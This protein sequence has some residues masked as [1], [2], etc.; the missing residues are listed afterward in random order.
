MS[1]MAGADAQTVLVVEDGLPGPARSV[2]L[3]L[4]NAE[5]DVQVAPNGPGRARQGRSPRRRR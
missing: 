5:Y 4:R 1:A 2:A 3:Y